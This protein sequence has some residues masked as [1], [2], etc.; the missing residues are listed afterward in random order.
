L[1][2]DEKYRLVIKL[3]NGALN[4]VEKNLL[5]GL[6]SEASVSHMLTSGAR[7]STRQIGQ[8]AGMKGLIINPAGRL[9]EFPIIPS[10]KEGLSP[11]EYFITTHG[12][13]KTLTDTALNTAKAGYLTRR[14]VYVA[15]DVVISEKECND[16]EGKLVSTALSSGFDRGI[17][18]LV[19]GR[20]LSKDVKTPDGKVL[21]SKGHYINSDEAQKI[22]DAKIT[23]AYIRTLLTCKS[24]HGVCQACYGQDLGRGS[25]VEIGEP[26]GI[27]AAQAIGEPGTQLTMRTKHSGG[28]DVGGDIV[29]GLP[30]VEEI[31]ERRNPKNPAL[32]ATV[33][34]MVSDIKSDNK[35]VTITVLAEP[36][37]KTKGKTGSVDY[38]APLVREV[39]VKKGD[40]IKIGQML[41]DGPADLQ[42][43]F[44]YAGKD[45]AE[46]YIINEIN[47]IYELQGASISRKHIEVIIRQMFSRRRIKNT[48]DT[49][50]DQGDVV[51]STEFIEANR[52]T[53]DAGGKEA[54]GE[55]IL[56]G[57]SEV[58][59][60]TS[61]FISAV[62][63]A[64]STKI[65]IRT[66]IKGGLDRL[67]GLKENVIIGRLI[68][69]GTGLKAD[70]AQMAAPTLTPPPVPEEKISS[71]S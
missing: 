39:L 48:G 66:A 59:L 55:T 63:F 56:L 57:I 23:E 68:P 20:V 46:E 29:G 54:V 67:R 11:L 26:V 71:A 60:T 51:E 7:G 34:G 19:R 13:R 4:K 35:E 36:G 10:Y 58:S 17:A 18:R 12:S 53:H 45:A 61:S 65:L 28:V 37:T 49:N 62:S 32:I 6:D 5:E 40:A 70:Y 38:K 1:S 24:V 21:F 50:F 52:T 44:R 47:K 25:L 43:L 16:T 42:E 33:D 30:R 3:W 27:V 14:L 41:T 15:E 31:F 8:M 64:Q 9:I 2:K 69:A 22:E